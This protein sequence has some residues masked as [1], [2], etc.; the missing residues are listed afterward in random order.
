M[1]AF[2]YKR[3]EKRMDFANE[4]VATLSVILVGLGAWY[5]TQGFVNISQGA[6]EEN[7]NQRKKG[8]MQI[9]GGIAL[10][11]VALGLVLQLVGLFS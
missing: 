10:G 3:K 4:A 7:D 6:A 9:A 11:F 1:P 8:F 5:G 2:C